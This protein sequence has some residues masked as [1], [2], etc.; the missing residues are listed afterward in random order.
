M[1]SSA[2]G[3]VRLAG[4]RLISALDFGPER[5]IVLIAHKKSDGKFELVGAGEAKSQG[6]GLGSI[7]NLGDAVEAVYEAAGKAESAAGTKIKTIYYNFDDPSLESV[8]SKGAVSLKGEGEIQISDVEEAEAIARRIVGHFEKMIVYAKADEYRIDDK[9]TVIN[10]L[11][12]FARRLEV[13]MHILQARASY[14]HAWD[15]LMARCHFPDAVRVLTPWSVAC[16]VTAGEA[17]A[18]K[19]LIVDL[20]ADFTS[21]MIYARHSILD[22]AVVLTKE[23]ED[24]R[25]DKRIRAAQ[26]ILSK[27]ADVREILVTGDLAEHENEKQAWI[28][29]AETIPVR[30]VAAQGVPKLAQP[31]FAAAAGL[32]W[33]AE[34]LQKKSPNAQ[35]DK[36]G[37]RQKAI[38]FI[39]EYF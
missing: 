28:E 9:D 22:C 37:L 20:G 6:I 2:R 18:D 16:G 1:W 33:A 39:Q 4:S 26:K 19:K 12:V 38:T 27:H 36:N 11:G 5:V 10:P 24:L 32:L 23:K 15:R 25:G 14:C 17:S 7:S 35:H 3:S 8:R 29:M 30:L 13:S 31:K 21:A 34:E